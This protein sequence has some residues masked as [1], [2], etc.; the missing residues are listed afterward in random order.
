MQYPQQQ[1]PMQQQPQ[2]AFE[3]S[4]DGAAFGM[5]MGMGAPGPSGPSGGP[6]AIDFHSQ[7]LQQQPQQQQQPLQL[8]FDS[9]FNMDGDPPVHMGGPE[10]AFGSSF[11]SA[12]PEGAPM[13]APG[14]LVASMGG[15]QGGPM[16]GP[17][18]V[19]PPPVLSEGEVQ[20]YDQL[21]REALGSGGP[22]GGPPGGP[23]EEY[24]DGA[25]AAAFLERSGLSQE[26]LHLIWELADIKN[27]GRSAII[28][29]LLLLLL[30]LLLFVTL[31]LLFVVLYFY[32][33]RMA[34]APGMSFVLLDDR[35]CLCL[36]CRWL[37]AYLICEGMA[38]FSLKRRR[39]W[40]PTGDQSLL[41]TNMQR[42][43]KGPHPFLGL[44][45][46]QPLISLY[47]T[48]SLLW[49]SPLY[50]CPCLCIIYV[51]YVLYII[52][53]CI[54][55]I[56][57]CNGNMDCVYLFLCSIPSHLP[58]HSLRICGCRSAVYVCIHWSTYLCLSAYLYIYI[59]IYVI[60]IISYQYVFYLL[61]IYVYLCYIT[62]SYVYNVYYVLYISINF[63]MP[64]SCWL[65][66]LAGCRLWLHPSV[67]IV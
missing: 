29:M 14:A 22:H 52:I 57:I 5:S 38:A 17:M 32:G 1:L 65:M 53:Y 28:L 45:P 51:Y 20:L 62:I 16:G 7:Q 41:R 31:L 64:A 39:D 43:P 26:T 34:E 30:L 44:W 40:S 12:T 36:D 46:A 6:P 35:I 21:W 24:L 37:F 47:L 2:F 56:C 58:R 13:G 23:E 60:C 11:P 55:Y 59:C 3:S 25:A 66:D 4:P 48:I 15:P 54:L 49:V 42:P 8:P 18:A 27:E 63:Y 61:Y 9:A 10:D 50:L 33:L 19:P 67:S